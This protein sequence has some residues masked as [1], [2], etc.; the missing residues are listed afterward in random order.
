MM[1]VVVVVLEVILVLVVTLG[2]VEACLVHQQLS[3]F[4]LSE[5]CYTCYQGDVVFSMEEVGKETHLWHE[6]H[7]ISSCPLLDHV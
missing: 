7:A 5:G 6:T 3:S 4:L 1:M 2:L